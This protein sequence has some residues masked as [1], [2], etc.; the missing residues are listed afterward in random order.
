MPKLFLTSQWFLPAFHV[1]F[2]RLAGKNLDGLR[3]A[4][5][6]NGADDE[7]GEPRWVRNARQS[8]VDAGMAVTR[9][10]LRDY[11]AHGMT[12]KLEEV[13]DRQDVIWVGGGNTFYL[14]WI[15]HKSGA[16][17][18]ITRLV[19]AGTIYGG[20]SAGAIV[21]G[22]TVE[23]FEE[24]DD[25]S[26]APELIPDGLRLIDT[27][28]LPHWGRNDYG[29]IMKAAEQKLHARGYRTQALTDTEALI[30]DGSAS[31]II[32]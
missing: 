14:N 11:L 17:K 9:V 20:G 7:E 1:E 5:I 31:R 16:A 27:V 23:G 13:F 8:L 29:E 28:I 12:A 30:I 32:S 25:A 26:F 2:E 22:P 21:A 3:T 10:D 15:L 24:A 4:L 19:E 18:I 6:E